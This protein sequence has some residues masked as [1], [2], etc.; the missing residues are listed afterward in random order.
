MFAFAIWDKLSRTLFLARDRMGVKPLYYA[1]DGVSLVFASE[2]KAVLAEPSVNRELNPTGIANYFSFGH[3]V[4]PDTIFRGVRKLLP[5]HYMVCRPSP[6]H[7]LKLEIT[8]YWQTPRRQPGPDR[9][10]RFYA[11][12]VMDL[13]ERSVARQM[14]ADVPVGVFLSG[15]LDSS[16]LTG[17]MS[18][19]ADGQVQ[20]FSVGF[21]DGQGEY[22]ELDASRLVARHFGTSHH[23]LIV[24]HLD[25]VGAIDEI[26]Y[27]YDE[28]FGDAASLP[29]LLVSKLARRH[30]TVVLSGEGSDEV[31]GGYRR[32]VAE[33]LLGYVPW[34]PGT[35][36][37]NPVQALLRKSLG[38]S[39]TKRLLRNIG[40]PDALSRYAGWFQVFSP[41]MQSE[42]LTEEWAASLAE[43]DRLSTY[44]SLYPR[45]RMSP[46]DRMLYMDQQTW[47]PDTYLEKVD[48]A[49]MAVGLEARVPFL[50]HELVEFAATIP[51]RYKVR[52]TRTK[53]ILKAATAG[54]LPAAIRNRKKHG[55]AVPYP[56]WFKGELREF[57]GDT[58]L[59]ASARQRG[60]LRPEAVQS[61][62]EQHQNGRESHYRQ[63]WVVL[64]FEAWCRRY[65]DGAGS[66]QSTHPT[67]PQD[68]AAHRGRLDA[69]VTAA[70]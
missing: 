25:V 17:L 33:K 3:S 39:R 16:T 18:D 29:T 32:Y 69:A 59:G 19:F 31:F 35:L 37:I 34:L 27:H 38:S 60:I 55:F 15:G 26:A 67:T 42:L 11:G 43:T 24:D 5:G 30:V 51:D 6:G 14:V 57:V 2:I 21:S 70:D 10:E 41:A 52:G 40:N 20:T 13:L 23:E 12:R 68:S 64:M 47:L 48:K 1:F 9:G 22:N 53:Y 49:S 7:R 63:L 46:V 66:W 28:P 4:A 36:S 62:I 58:L 45:A 61:L 44:R 54:L 65:L 50:D 8:R 56:L